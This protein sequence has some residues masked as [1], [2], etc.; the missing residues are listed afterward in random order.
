[1]V[2][3]ASCFFGAAVVNCDNMSNSRTASSKFSASARGCLQLKYVAENHDSTI[4]SK[5]VS[6]LI[7]KLDPPGK[8]QT[9]HELPVL[10]ATWRGVPLPGPP[11]K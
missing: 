6:A 10:G 3:R 9:E 8:I 2:N 1:M 7:A 4:T 11:L 5:C